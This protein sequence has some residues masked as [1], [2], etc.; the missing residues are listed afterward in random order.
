MIFPKAHVVCRFAHGRG[1]RRT[2]IR[3]PAHI[4]ARL[5]HHRCAGGEEELQIITITILTITV[6]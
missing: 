3:P 4:Y 6:F 2:P 1:T 5:V